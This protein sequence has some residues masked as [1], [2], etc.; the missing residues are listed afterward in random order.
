MSSP[1]AGEADLDPFQAQVATIS[2][3]A[4]EQWAFALA[5][6]NALVAHGLLTRPTQDV[7]LFTNTPHGPGDAVQVV[8]AA[9]EAV[10][11]RVSYEV[12]P[13]GEFARLHVTRADDEVIV[14]LARDWRAYPPVQMTVG[15]VLHR[16]DAV[17]SKVS[18]MV[19]R[20]LPRDF[21]DVA[22]A[23]AQYERGELL[24]LLFE[25]DPGIGPADVALAVRQLDLLNA[26]DF[27]PYGLGAAAVAH[28]RTMFEPWPR[29][30]D[31]DEQGRRVYA[32]AHPDT[33]A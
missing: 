14:D 17:S 8:V 9:L 23:L 30:A 16:D 10:G 19:G 1:S 6:G 22:A 5:G 21:I 2:L 3:A 29:D 32:E 25:R 26:E 31:G 18:A 28:V 15:L 24:R 33:E 4:T 20:G 13:D 11:L 12:A 7:D 27:A